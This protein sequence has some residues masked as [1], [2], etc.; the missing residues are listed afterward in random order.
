MKRLLLPPLLLALLS[1]LGCGNVFFGG[2]LRASST[3]QGSVTRVEL[4][5]VA[6]GNGGTIEVTFVTFLDGGRTSRVSFCNDQ[7]SLFPL[8]QSFRVNFN[9]GTPCSSLIIVMVLG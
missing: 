5:T 4:G 9:A 6:A 3:I 8:G 1:F 7:T 2:A